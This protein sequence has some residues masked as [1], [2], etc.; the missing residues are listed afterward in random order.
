MESVWIDGKKRTV[1]GFNRE[2]KKKEEGGMNGK[3]L[4]SLSFWLQVDTF[5]L[6]DTI[7]WLGIG[8]PL[9]SV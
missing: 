8:G 1:S 5:G 4:N 9:R 3:H 7:H 6:S 2:V